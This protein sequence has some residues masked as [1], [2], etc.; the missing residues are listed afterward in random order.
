MVKLSRNLIEYNQNTRL[1]IEIDLEFNEPESS[2]LDLK[3]I[4]F[5]KRESNQLEGVGE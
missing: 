2:C 5:S 1:R 3:E 4:P